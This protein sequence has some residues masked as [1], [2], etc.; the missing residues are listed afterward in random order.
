[1][2]T[3]TDPWTPP[4]QPPPQAAY[5]PLAGFDEPWRPG[6]PQPPAPGAVNAYQER[7]T[8]RALLGLAVVGAL[9]TAL[10]V[11]GLWRATHHHTP[12]PGG[13]HTATFFDLSTLQD[14]VQQAM[15]A[16]LA[17]PSDPVYD[18]GVTVT[19]VNCIREA[20]TQTFDCHA[21][22]SNGV[23]TSPTIVVAADGQRWVSK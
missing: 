5:P 16:R 6:A 22:L 17:N 11:G 12:G 15:D 8:F 2:T 10:V 1:M 18:P 3:P 7:R 19:S 20:Q 4:E 21:E 9:V 23:I 14:S 13:S